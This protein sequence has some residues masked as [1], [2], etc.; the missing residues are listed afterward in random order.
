MRKTILLLVFAAA[1]TTQPA[2]QATTS[3][4]DTTTATS[5]TTSSTATATNQPA[6]SPGAVPIPARGQVCRTAVP[7]KAT[8]EAEGQQFEDRWLAENYPGATGTTRS[9]IDCKGMAVDEVKFRTA[10]GV[11]RTLYF[12]ASAFA[13]K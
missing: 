9:R 7:V 13:G 5:A 6:Y 8:T 2:P 12:D 10:N 3:A 11:D 1:C 4:P